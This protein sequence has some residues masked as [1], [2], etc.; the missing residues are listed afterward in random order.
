MT[1]LKGNWTKLRKKHLRKATV[2]SVYGNPL[3][4]MESE[5]I[6]LVITKPG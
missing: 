1:F 2:S 4:T 6:L 5:L 3:A